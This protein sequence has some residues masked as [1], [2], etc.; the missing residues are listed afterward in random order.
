MHKT[1]ILIIQLCALFA[2]KVVKHHF[3]LDLVTS[4]RIK[5]IIDIH[6]MK[7]FLHYRVICGKSQLFGT[8]NLSIVRS[9]QQYAKALTS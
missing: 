4:G 1:T 5:A 2:N 8:I 3:R 7:R 9:V 6:L